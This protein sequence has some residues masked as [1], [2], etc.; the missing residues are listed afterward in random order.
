MLSSTVQHPYLAVKD[1]WLLYQTVCR[2]IAG[3]SELSPDQVQSLMES[4][5][6]RYSGLCL[7]D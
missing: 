3:H 7:T 1:E 6:V 4:I 5:R 2:Y